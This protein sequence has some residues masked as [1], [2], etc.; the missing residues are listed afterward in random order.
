MAEETLAGILTCDFGIPPPRAHRNWS[1]WHEKKWN[2]ETALAWKLSGE[3]HGLGYY[4]HLRSLFTPNEPETDEFDLLSR[5]DREV[6]PLLLRRLPKA[7]EGQPRLY[8]VLLSHPLDST[9]GESLARE[10]DLSKS[11]PIDD[12]KPGGQRSRDEV[13]AFRLLRYLWEREEVVDGIVAAFTR[14]LSW[15]HLAEKTCSLEAMLDDLSHWF[16]RNGSWVDKTYHVTKQ[17]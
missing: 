3:A 10:L 7:A 6:T 1:E 8:F 4:L 14:E 16:D 11:S 12:S 5:V 15:P 13:R 17:G 9:T 2:A